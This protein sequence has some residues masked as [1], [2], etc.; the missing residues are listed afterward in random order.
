MKRT[1][2]IWKIVLFLAML[3]LTSF[4]Q[5]RAQNLEERVKILEEQ[6][7]LLG[8]EKKDEGMRVIWKNDLRFQTLDKQVEIRIGGRLNVDWNFFLP[9]DAIEAQFGDPEDR[10][11]FRRARIGIRGTLYEFI[12]FKTE[13]DFAEN[14]DD[15][16]NFTDAYIQLL[17]IPVVGT[18]TIGQF[19]VPFAL[20]QLTSGRF[21]TFQE[22]ALGTDAFVLGREIGVMFNNHLYEGRLTWAVAV[23]RPED[24]FGDTTLE[25]SLGGDYNVTVRLT[26]A[27]WIPTPT[28][29]VHLG[30]A[31]SYRNPPGNELR[32]RARPEARIDSLRLVDTGTLAT[33]EAH[34]LGVEGAMVYGPLSVQGEYMLALPQLVDPALDDPTFWAFYVQ[35]SYFLTGE[36]RPYENGIFGRPRP[37]HNV[38]FKKGGL[39]AWE[40]AARFS[41]I[42]LD[43][44]ASI[45]PESGGEERNVTFG[46]NWYPTPNTRITWN[47]VYA[48]LDRTI[49]DGTVRTVLNGEDAHIVQMRFQVDF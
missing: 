45:D 17:K 24:D 37:K 26:G 19:Q 25:N 48:N 39:G 12:G 27:P 43:D 28:Q 33:R 49:N 16:V 34:Q 14:P 35:I 29:L 20:E 22:R 15:G 11:F 4:K 41:W 36:H 31:Y 10:I 6:T 2:N 5:P 38:N 32:Y 9:N 1:P 42:D 8:A 47:Y 46:V 3:I 21:I 18:L 13:Y 30:F 40:V 44:A 23:T 7:K